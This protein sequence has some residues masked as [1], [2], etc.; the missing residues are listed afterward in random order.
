M[1]VVQDGL[2][3]TAKKIGHYRYTLLGLTAA[4]A[5]LFGPGC[6]SQW[7][8]K[9]ADPADPTGEREVDIHGLQASYNNATGSLD[10]QIARAK[11][12]ITLLMDT[13]ES[14]DGAY[15]TKAEQ[16]NA[17]FA[18]RDTKIGAG[19]SMIE[20]FLGPAAPY[21]PGALAAFG[22][23]AAGDGVRRSILLKKARTGDTA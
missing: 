20:G 19:L 18:D 8:G 5:L 2:E 9:V 12:E 6:F 4:A 14:L 22:I 16:I 21:L 13:R 10:A 1:D 7:D 11:T 23:G 17:E 3:T 15:T